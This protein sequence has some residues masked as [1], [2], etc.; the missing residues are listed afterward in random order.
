MGRRC[1]CGCRKEIKP[2][3]QCTS[4]MEKLGFYSMEC[5]EKAAIAA[6]NKAREKKAAKPRQSQPKAGKTTKAALLALNKRDVR[7]QHKKTQVAFNRMRVLEELLWFKERNI[8]PI[9][10][11]CRNPLRNDQWCCG[12]F[13]T[14]GAYS[15]IRYDRKN[16]FLQHNHR[17]NMNLSGDIE[18]TKTTCGYKVGLKVRFGDDEAQSI[19]DYCESQTQPVKWT[20]EGLEAMRKEFNCRAREIELQLKL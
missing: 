12:H 11:S 7:W 13:K 8:E 3:R 15:A 5:Q 18:G 4:Y 9:C 2:A 20:C 1:K 6:L 16:T 19:I 10:I 17:C 14:V